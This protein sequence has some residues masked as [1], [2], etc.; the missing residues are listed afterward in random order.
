MDKV[1]TQFFRIIIYSGLIL[2]SIA[3]LTPFVWLLCAAFKQRKDFIQYVF[4]PDN[5]AALTINNFV[6]LFNELPFFKYIVNTL[7]LATGQTLLVLLLASMGGFALAKYQFRGK[8]VVF[9]IMLCSMMVPGQVLLAP[10]Y[11]II[12]NFG[13]IDSYFGILMPGAVN[14]F[15]LFLCRQAMLSVPDDLLE[16]A[17]IDGA[18][19]WLVYWMVMLPLSRPILGAITIITFLGSWN[20]FMWP[21]IVLRNPEK[22]TLAIGIAHMQGSHGSDYGIIMAGTVISILPIMAFFLIM[23]REFIAGLTSGAVKG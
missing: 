17:R 8:P 19:E 6:R 22:Y 15:A 16:A 21:Q 1:Q 9:A 5:L 10:L 13:W 11:E 12:F 14:V 20:A 7:F 23:Q 3:T 2:A 18:S 4:L